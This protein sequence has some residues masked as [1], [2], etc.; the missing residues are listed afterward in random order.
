MSLRSG[1]QRATICLR[2]STG[3]D[4]QTEENRRRELREF[5]EDEGYELAGEY[6]DQQAS[7]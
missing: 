7:T 5:I 1:P 2:V 3:G 4:K 6:V